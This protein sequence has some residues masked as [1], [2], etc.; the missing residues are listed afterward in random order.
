MGQGHLL[1]TDGSLGEAAYRGEL[2][3]VEDAVLRE[4]GNAGIGLCLR[5]RR[6]IGRHDR[7]IK[8]KGDIMTI[9]DRVSLRRHAA[10]ILCGA[11]DPDSGQHSIVLGEVK[12][13]ELSRTY[14]QGQ[15][16]DLR[17]NAS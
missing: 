11:R 12:E 17:R 3:R 10:A 2:R 1:R 8:I 16:I 6:R 13:L 15:L 9:L 5:G 4:A 7:S 14:R